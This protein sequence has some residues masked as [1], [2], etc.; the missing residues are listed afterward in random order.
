MK[1]IEIFL[2]IFVNPPLEFYLVF[3]LFH[4]VL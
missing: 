1:I 3:E 4:T 2:H